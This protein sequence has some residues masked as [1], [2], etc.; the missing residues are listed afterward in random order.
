MQPA[1]AAQLAQA[2]LCHQQYGTWRITTPQPGKHALADAYCVIDSIHIYHS[3]RIHIQHKPGSC[4][5]T[6]LNTHRWPTPAAEY[7]SSIGLLSKPLKSPTCGL[8]DPLNLAFCR[9]WNPCPSLSHCPCVTGCSQAGTYCAAQAETAGLEQVE[10]GAYTWAE[11]QGVGYCQGMEMNLCCVQLVCVPGGG[12]DEGRGH[13]FPNFSALPYPSK[14]LHQQS[15]PPRHQGKACA[16]YMPLLFHCATGCRQ[17]WV[18]TAQ[19]EGTS[20]SSRNDWKALNRCVYVPMLVKRW[21]KGNCCWGGIS[22]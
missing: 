14:A 1:Q 20:V 9:L 7:C 4:S 6:C 12:S 18:F 3:H 8:L 10:A 11:R 2:G 15:I 19:A 16:Y 13:S 5:I 21:E 17:A 22:S